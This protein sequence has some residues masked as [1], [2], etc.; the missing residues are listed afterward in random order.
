VP[1]VPVLSMLRIFLEPKHWSE[2]NVATV[3][4][5][6]CRVLGATSRFDI[7]ITLTTTFYDPNRAA[8]AATARLMKMQEDDPSV[9]LRISDELGDRVFVARFPRLAWEPSGEDFW[10]S[11]YAPG[12]VKVSSQQ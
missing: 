12:A 2:E 11:A 7:G 3:A 6:I 8:A 10:Q 5:E 1:G 9:A 4:R